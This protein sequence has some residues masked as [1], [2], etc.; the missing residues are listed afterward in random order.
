[1]CA[2]TRPRSTAVS[3]CTKRGINSLQ[4]NIHVR[5]QHCR[6]SPVAVCYV[7]RH[8]F[9][10]LAHSLTGTNRAGLVADNSSSPVQ[11]VSARALSCCWHRTRLPQEH[12]TCYILCQN[13]HWP[14]TT[15]WSCHALGSSS[16]NVRSASPP[17]ERGT[18]FLLICAPL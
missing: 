14:R 18:V 5:I 2:T 15:T 3:S 8:S 13:V 1:M 4:G 10:S 9:E 16:A 7:F 12:A 17:R 6:R 11:T